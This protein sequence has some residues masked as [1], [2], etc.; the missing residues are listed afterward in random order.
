LRLRA[1]FI[2]QLRLNLNIKTYFKRLGEEPG[3]NLYSFTLGTP[4]PPAYSFFSPFLVKDN[5]CN[6]K[7]QT[8]DNRKLYAASNPAKAQIA[9]PLA[10]RP[11]FSPRVGCGS[12][13]IFHPG[14]SDEN[15]VSSQLRGV[16]DSAVKRILRKLVDLTVTLPSVGESRRFHSPPIFLPR[17]VPRLDS[18][19][20]YPPRRRCCPCFYVNYYIPHY[21]PCLKHF[22]ELCC[23][24]TVVA[25][26]QRP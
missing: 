7:D 12:Q 1:H 10:N 6:E 22:F 17:R 3:L 14:T 8:V 9:L 24:L 25:F 13:R 2:R 20:P 15:R 19:R 16:V 5:C 18:A 21:S 4:P 26:P 11:D 23:A